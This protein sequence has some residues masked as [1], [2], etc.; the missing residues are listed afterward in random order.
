MCD[1]RAREAL[2]IALLEIEYNRVKSLVVSHLFW[3]ALENSFEGDKHSKKLRR[4]SWICVFQDA[5][6]MEDES[7]R[8][9]IGRI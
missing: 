3:K 5:K 8:T 1:M 7:V 6:I 2:L 4:Q 9:Y